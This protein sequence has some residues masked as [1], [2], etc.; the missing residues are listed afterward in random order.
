MNAHTPQSDAWIECARR[1]P[2]LE[3]AQWVGAKLK[4]AGGE[5]VGPCPGCG[6]TDRFSI[7]PKENI[8][9]CRGAQGGKGT[10]NLVMHVNNCGF[11]DAVEFITKERRP[12]TS[13]DETFEQ[14]QAREKRVADWNAASA[15]RAA[16]EARNAT[17]KLQHDLEAVAAVLARSRPIG[18]T[19]A[20]DYLAARGLTPPRRFLRDLRFVEALTYYG[21]ASEQARE[22]TRL[23]TLSAMVAIVRDA[24]GDVVGIH[25]TYL[26]PH[27]A[28]KWRGMP[29]PLRNPAKKVRKCVEHMSGAMIRL[30]AIGD[31]LVL[32]EGV[33]AVLSY[34][35]LDRA[36]DDASFACAMSLGNLCGSATGTVQ[37]RTLKDK[38]GKPAK[39]RNGVPAMDRPGVILP[40]HVRRLVL[41]GD[42]D[43][44]TIATAASMLCAVRRFR[45]QGLEVRIAMAPSGLDFNDVLVA[46]GKA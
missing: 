24:A 42:D 19:H 14:R 41:L 23:A 12:N 43:S 1:A 32:G 35:A 21:Y 37:H 28:A 36:P 17:G 13:K 40:A 15:Q 38:A 6:G 7:N 9:N 8:W 29:D 26:D 2:I 39:V 20:A 45:S 31:T 5:W 4:R 10:I 44:E 16:A 22:K 46:R 34:Q 30:G 33:E 18:G 25:L 3:V 27:T 11:V